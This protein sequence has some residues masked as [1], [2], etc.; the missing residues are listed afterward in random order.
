M[1][2]NVLIGYATSEGQTA[3][4]AGAIGARLAA[5]GHTVTEVDLDRS[6]PN[7]AGFDAVV[8]G[9]SVHVGW[10]QDKLRCYVAAYASRLNAMPSWF[11]AVSLAEGIRKGEFT[12]EKALRQIQDFLGELQWEPREAL[13]VG[14]ALLYREY[15]WPKRL[16]MKQIVRKNGGDTDTSRDWEYTDWDA[17]HAFAGRI[18]AAIVAPAARELSHR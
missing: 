2:T 11:F 15:S 6:M 14:G 10:F 13:S 4:V 16:M 17:V 9:G 18:S 3:K 8:L 1:T 5:L 12:H 7:P